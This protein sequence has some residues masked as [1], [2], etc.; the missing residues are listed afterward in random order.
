MTDHLLHLRL[1]LDLLHTHHFVAKIS[2][3]VFAAPT[4]NYLGHIISAEG[5][6]PDLDK[7]STILDWAT[8]RS[9][10]KLRGFLGLTGF[11]RRFVYHYATIAARLQIY[12]VVQDSHGIRMRKPLLHNSKYK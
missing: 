11:Y 1:I 10:T 5:V 3:C 2:K 7:G 6:A 4:I 8:P 9:F 12:K